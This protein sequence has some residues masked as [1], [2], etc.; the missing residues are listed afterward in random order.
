MGSI[1]F[2]G[3]GSWG[4]SDRLSDLRFGQKRE[5]QTGISQE[6]DVSFLGASG[7]WMLNLSD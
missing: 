5:G 4:A 3:K 2:D 7:V 1:H 6:P